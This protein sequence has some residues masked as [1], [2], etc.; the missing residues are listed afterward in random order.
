MRSPPSGPYYL[1]EEIASPFPIKLATGA[2]Q[3][4]AAVTLAR[5][6]TVRVSAGVALTGHAEPTFFLGVTP[7]HPPEAPT[8]TSTDND[9]RAPH[10]VFFA[11]SET[12]EASPYFQA[13]TIG[14]D[15]SF[16]IGRV[17][18]VAVK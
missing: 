14:S 9:D 13:S 17:I 16:G 1:Y 18:A 2:T 15:P 5:D 3:S 4:A 7:D 8:A 10:K 12:E 11:A 6:I